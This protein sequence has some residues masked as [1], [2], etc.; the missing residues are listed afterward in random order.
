MN[1]KLQV[2]IA[3]GYFFIIAIL[4]VLL[5][6]FQVFDMSFTYKYIVHTHSHVAL[7]GWIYTALTS[8]IYHIYLANKSIEKKYRRLFWFTQITIIGMMVT[9]PLQGYA[10]L[11]I[12]FSTLFLIA[13]YAFTRMFL[14]HTS[15]EQK[16]TQS[17][18]CIRT[19][20]WLMVFSSIGPWALGYIMNTFGS[21]SAWY[22]NAIYFYLH[23]Q[24]NGWFLLAICGM[25]FY[26]LEQHQLQLPQKLFTWF[27][28][29][30][31]AGV[32]LTFFLSVLW[33][34]PS[35]IIYLIAGTGAILQLVAFG[36]LYLNIYKRR[37]EIKEVFSSR[38]ITLLVLVAIFL[39]IKLT[40]Q[41]LGSFQKIAQYVS[42]N[43][44]LVISYIHLVF[45]G[46]VSISILAFYHQIR[47]ITIT[48]TS[49]I[50]Y[51]LGFIFTE[52]LLFYKG[53]ATKIPDHYYSYLFVASIILC[54][55]IALFFIQ[56]F[57]KKID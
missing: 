54:L 43:I 17:Y 12:L 46:I 24:Y 45:L 16:Q 37:V 47:V 57:K 3:V 6:S 41:L 19:A 49:F 48:K 33:I 14:K 27:Y 40:S 25:L 42:N 18:I 52:S 1:L 2:K 8:L 7:L 36:I 39:D 26:Y 53:F 13:S 50:T 9:F 55:G 51:L 28:R 30:L 4:G 21:T 35:I 34:N 23:F 29:L 44:D 11:S 31:I 22:R 38:V 15:V 32:F 20:L 56:L 10:L 5:R